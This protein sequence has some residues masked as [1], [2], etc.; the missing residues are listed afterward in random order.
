MARRIEQTLEL[1]N[2]L[3]EREIRSGKRRPMTVTAKVDSGST[4]TV[5][6]KRIAEE[7]ELVSG[8]T[9]SV[10]Y[11]DQR[12]ARL[13][14][15]QGLKVRIPGLPGREI[16]TDAVVEPHRTTVLLGC[17][18]MERMDLVADHRAGVLRP[19]PGT[20]KGITAE[21]D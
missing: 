6:P 18:E 9:V 12:G 20:E 5:L 17:E 2:F 11:A 14:L 3:H 21:I 1:W 10:R 16:T 7:L 4:Y 19:R 8:G 13:R 15:V